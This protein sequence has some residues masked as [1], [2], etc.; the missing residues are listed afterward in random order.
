MTYDG[1]TKFHLPVC[2]LDLLVGHHKHGVSGGGLRV[3]A[4]FHL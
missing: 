2:L 1:L 4:R 3:V